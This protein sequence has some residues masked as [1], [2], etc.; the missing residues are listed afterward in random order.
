MTENLDVLTALTE[1]GDEI[2]RLVRPLAAEQWALP[3]PAPG[4]SIAHQIAHLIANFRLAALSAARPEAFRA[5]T[6]QLSDDFDAN[7][8][9][10]MAEHLAEPP[11]VLLDRF[12]TQLA[13]AVKAISGVPATAHVPWLVN[14][15]PPAV[16]AAAGLMEM[17]AHGRD[18]A[19]ALR[20][21][22][23][24]TDRIRHIV[25]FG[26]RTRDFGYLARGLT[27]PAEEFRFELT[28]PS[29]A[30]WDFGPPGAADRVSGPAVDFCL[31]VTR[32][33]HHRDLALTA[34]GDRAA[35]WLEIAQAYR[36]P[37]GA[38]R[39]PGQFAVKE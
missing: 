34:E 24:Y 37:A 16:L 10:A 5:L 3:T 31:L 33:R 17:F 28:G 14:P 7:V 36:G 19:D 15:L 21:R 12:R 29:G 18:I 27:P 22:L 4:W 11:S 1:E 35:G 39:K 6:A 20:K 8:R 25:A 30:R 13:T 9:N 38:G 23:D 32:R 26:V 2:Y